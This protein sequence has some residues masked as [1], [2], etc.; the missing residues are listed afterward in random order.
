MNTNSD[1]KEIFKKERY[2]EKD[3]EKKEKGEEE[4]EEK[5]NERIN[6]ISKNIPELQRSI[7]FIDNE[8]NG[9]DYEQAILIDFR[10]LCKS[11]WSLLKQTHII[12]FTF[13]TKDDYNLFFSKISLFLMSLA[14]NIAS[15]AL[16][17][18]DGSMH[19]LYEDYGEFDFLY[20]LPQT[21]YSIII[22]SLF[23]TLFEFLSLSEDIISGFKEDMNMKHI[24]LKKQKII[25]CLII[26]NIIF[27]ILGLIILLFFW[28]YVSCFCAV[29]SNTQIPLMKDTFISYFTGMI[30]PFILILIPTIIRIPALESKNICLYKFSRILTTVINL[31]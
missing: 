16:F 3:I 2:N 29:Y 28:Y 10:S 13:I 12:I 30:Y 7:Y 23:T 11:Y 20:N 18:T 4:K 26:K 5:N 1:N 6:Q 31:I 15:N 22:S 14:L 21:I 8:I 27:F 25:R 24:S 17:F 9:L 19:K